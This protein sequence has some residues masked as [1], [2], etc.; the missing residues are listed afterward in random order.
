MDSNLEIGLN[1]LAVNCEWCQLIHVWDELVNSL[2]E[3]SWTFFILHKDCFFLYF[4]AGFCSI[5]VL[6]F[7]ATIWKIAYSVI[8]VSVF[9]GRRWNFRINLVKFWQRTQIC[10]PLCLFIDTRHANSANCSTSYFLTSLSFVSNSSKFLDSIKDFLQI[11][12]HHE[13]SIYSL[14]FKLSWGTSIGTLDGFSKFSLVNLNSMQV[15]MPLPELSSII[16]LVFIDSYSLSENAI[17]VSNSPLTLPVVDNHL[18]PDD[19]ILEK[20]EFVHVCLDTNVVLRLHAWET[21]FVLHATFE[22]KLLICVSLDWL[23]YNH[24]EFVLLYIPLI[25]LSDILNVRNSLWL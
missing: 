1:T 24:I 8:F 9:T 15:I 6:F 2:E 17:D 12:L 13:L 20:D 25:L 16:I 19:L 23:A 5:K 4:L 11:E 14:T 7:A 22:V 3:F 10:Y 21:S 18:Y